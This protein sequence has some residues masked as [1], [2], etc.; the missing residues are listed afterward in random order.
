VALG[1]SGV[2]LLAL[3]AEVHPTSPKPIAKTAVLQN[4]PVFPDKFFNILP[5]ER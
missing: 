5:L 1:L 4:L 2:E 3:G